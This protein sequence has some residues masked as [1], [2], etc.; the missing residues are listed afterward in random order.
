MVAAPIY[1]EFTPL[2]FYTKVPLSL[3]SCRL[4][5]DDKTPVV[6]L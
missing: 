2:F 4:F 1:V 5:Y 6:A 3:T